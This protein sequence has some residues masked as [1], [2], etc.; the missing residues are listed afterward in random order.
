MSVSDG[1]I[2]QFLEGACSAEE[3]ANIERWLQDPANMER[4]ARRSELHADLRRSLHRNRILSRALEQGGDEFRGAPVSLKTFGS[5]SRRWLALTAAGVVAAACL[6]VV[7]VAN[8]RGKA[9]LP[10]V[11]QAA[12]V[13][14]DVDALLSK[15]GQRWNDVSLPVGRYR[16]RK[17]L[18]NLQFGNGVLVYLEAPAK[19]DAMSDERVMLY[20]GRLSAHVP[21]EGIGFTVQ[22]PEAEV[23][24]FGTEFSVDVQSGA[25]EVHVFDGLV[26][27][28]P[29]RAMT[30]ESA[31]AIDLKA[32]QAVRVSDP[33]VKPLGI[34]IA[35]ERFIRNFDE[36][37][38][39]YARRIK[40]LSPLAYYRMPIR[41]R[42]LISEP[43]EYS[44]MV[45]TG[46]GV[47]PP[48]ACGLFGGSLRVGADSTGRGGHVDSPPELSTG[49][50]T[51]TAFVYLETSGQSGI[52]ATNMDGVRGGYTLDL[53][54]SGNLQATLQSQDGDEWSVTGDSFLPTKTWRYVVVSVDGERLRLFEDGKLVGSVESAPMISG[55]SDGIWFGTDA[56]SKRIWHGRIDEL[57]LFDRALTQEEIAGL[58]RAAQEEIAG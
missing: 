41:D 2:D 51:L 37:R 43:P 36:P 29:G 38:Q 54:E 56:R 40:Q 22:T 7:L 10:Y 33:M 19:F 39:K 52:V 44:G 32:S 23:V 18:L 31:A 34:A 14:M 6:L 25:S 1:L 49:Q 46:D 15:D 48:H 45:L 50:F 24:D 27:V 55:P 58:Y 3:V 5:P 21:P 9:R 16:L 4:F 20:N 35:S 12:T 13:V 28:H 42:G 26:R 17:G 30:E 47:R 11:S 53:N 57:A 8:R